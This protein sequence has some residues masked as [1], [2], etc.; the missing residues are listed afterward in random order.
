MAKLAPFRDEAVQRP[1]D[2][3]VRLNE[4]VS[5][6]NGV[7][8]K[9]RHIR[10]QNVQLGVQVALT[11]PGFMVGAVIVASAR[12]TAGGVAPTAAPWAQDVIQQADGRLTFFVGGL[13]G[14]ALYAVDVVLVEFG[15]T[16]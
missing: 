1:D 3:R 11:A 2:L 16:S 12:P 7:S 8:T 5:V 14:S 13:S 10:L 4:L 9:T 6:V 15:G